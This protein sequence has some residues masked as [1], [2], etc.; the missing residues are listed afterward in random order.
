MSAVHVTVD[1]TGQR[2][3]QTD[4]DTLLR[5]ALRAGV[6][7]PYE[8]NAGGCG[9]CRIQ[10][11]EGDV[12]DLWPDAPGR[13]DRD[14]RSGRLLACQTRATSD[15]VIR[16]RTSA[17]YVGAVAPRRE[18]ATVVR[19]EP[20]TH[21]LRRFVLRTASPAEFAP[22]QYLSLFLPDVGAA[23]N[24]SMANLP[25]ADGEWELIVRRVRG[26]AATRRLFDDIHVG[27]EVDVDGPYGLATLRAD[28]ERD[29]VC[30]AGGSGLAPMLSIA[31]GAAAA[32]L[33]GRHRVHFFYGARTPAD[34]CGGAELER[35]DGF[36]STIHF[37][38]VVSTPADEHGQP[39][40][41]LTGYVH[42]AV[43]ATVADRL[44]NE[45]GAFEWYCAGPPPMTQALQ[46]ALV[47]D[48]GVPVGQV[49]Y[50]RFF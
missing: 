7:I 41:G 39:W 38:P 18:R 42:E 2:F 49:H 8:C 43:L 36:G 47:L 34:V 27:D 31:R 23:R 10:V 30:V 35:L 16:V 44:V 48:C 37:H 46:S 14:R 50:D 45:P 13:S 22:G 25:N 4:D 26:G 11:G 15:A 33:L 9:S 6:G 19:V 32:G 17:E 24:Y 29:I 20:V 12:E 5:A 28:A 1:G 3:E 21:D 40:D